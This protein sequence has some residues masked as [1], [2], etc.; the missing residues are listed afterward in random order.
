MKHT[1]HY[2][3][4][5]WEANDKVQRTDF[6]ADNAK[7]DAALQS[8]K[9]GKGNCKIITG[10][11][12]GNGEC[13]HFHKNSLSFPQQPLMVF[14]QGDRNCWMICGSELASVDGG[15]TGGFINITWNGSTVSWYGSN[16]HDQLNVAS[17]IYRYT[18]VIVTE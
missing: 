1:E 5:Q 10:Q 2:Q 6:N 11:Y 3:L 16:D 14:I 9:T 8:L 15:S 4:N 17:A 7:I 12:R 13:D 18:A